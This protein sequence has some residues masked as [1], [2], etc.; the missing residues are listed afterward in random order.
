MAVRGVDFMTLRAQPVA[1]AREAAAVRFDRHLQRM[2]V[3]RSVHPVT[4]RT[5][6]L[7][8]PKTARERERLRA[9]EAARTAVGPE[10]TLRIVLR[11]RL[12]DEKRQRE[13][14]VAVARLEPEE[15]VVLVAVAVAAGIEDLPR[16]CLLRREDPELR[17]GR[18]GRFA[19]RILLPVARDGDVRRARTVTGF[20]ADAH[21]GPRGRVRLRGR[22]EILRQFRRV[23]VD[24]GDVPDL[25][26]LVIRI[27]GDR[28][29]LFPIDPP[30]RLVVPEHR[31][32]VDPAVRQLRE[33]P[34]EPARAERV[35]DLELFSR[36]LVVRD[37]DEV[38]AVA[39]LHR[40][41]AAVRLEPNCSA[42][43]QCGGRVRAPGAPAS[44][45][46]GSPTR[47][48]RWG[49]G[50]APRAVRKAEITLHAGLGNRLR[51]LNVEGLTPGVIG[52][53]VTALTLLRADIPIIIFILARGPTLLPR[54]GDPTPTA[55]AQRV[56]ASQR[57]KAVA[58]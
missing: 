41:R 34:L 3:G 21:F 18:F 12:A 13:I 23:A 50:G 47:Q 48:P 32:H 11:N 57:L 42:C 29:D 26:Q 53:F 2:I 40:V 49:A 31:Q 22:M 30:P 38:P 17:G 51:H 58:R 52:R 45:G 39:R 37:R 28:R 14:L 4:A 7:A 43:G 24:A 55:V 6:R 44:G 33:I 46:A 19:R 35:V 8:F 10:I 9:I 16:V 1:L 36:P 15:D 54:G 27:A 25:E 5:R 56:R 20:A